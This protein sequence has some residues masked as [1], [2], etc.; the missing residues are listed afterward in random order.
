MRG[1]H[2]RAAKRAEPRKSLQGRQ[3]REVTNLKRS[4]LLFILILAAMTVM[5]AAPCAGQRDR[6][7]LKAGGGYSHPF[8]PNLSSELEF[9][10]REGVRGGF[11]GCISLGR[12]LWER[13]WAV[14][15]L[16]AISYYPSFDYEN[17]YDEFKG[18][19]SHYDFAAVCKKCLLPDSE[20]LIPYIGAGIG[21]GIT[22]LISGGGRIRT[23]HALALAQ[24]E[25][26]LR[27]N[28]SFLVEAAYGTALEKDTFENAFLEDVPGDVV[29]D[30]SGAPVEDRYSAL[31]VRIGI[32]Q[33]LRPPPDERE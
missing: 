2:G 33:W 26:P 30:S 31:N 20:R 4:T 15:F 9:Q 5:L 29:L 1:T 8:L 14:E 7:F 23:V 13:Q 12:T 11:G 32:I 3:A 21:Y 24:L 22:N 25:V 18:R 6:F 19:M 17:E 16:V 10:G 28:T 27:D